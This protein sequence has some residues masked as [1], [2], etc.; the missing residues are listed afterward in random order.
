MNPYA[1]GEVYTDTGTGA[2]A[3]P[4]ESVTYGA[5]HDPNP[6]GAV[7]GPPVSVTVESPPEH[8]SKPTGAVE[9]P[10]SEVTT[11]QHPGKKAV[12]AAQVED[13]ALKA[14]PPADAVTEAKSA[15]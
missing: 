3:G 11:V 14:D 6:T 13:K 1:A 8:L 12:K 4:P 10:P 2:Y 15:D 5:E 9:G 7:D